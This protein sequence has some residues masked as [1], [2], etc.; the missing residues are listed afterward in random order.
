M[1]ELTITLT[2]GQL[3]AIAERIAAKVSQRDRQD[4]E[5]LDSRCAAQHLGISRDKLRKLAAGGA[6][7]SE[8]DAPGCKRYFRRS[9]LDRWRQNGGAPAHLRSVT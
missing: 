7:L 9:A 1:I 3:D 5:W 6:I 8:Q 4:D 2:D